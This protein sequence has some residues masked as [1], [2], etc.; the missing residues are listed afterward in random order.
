MISMECE[1]NFRSRLFLSL[2]G[3]GI[4]G[5]LLAGYTLVVNSLSVSGSG[6]WGVPGQE[7]V[8]WLCLLGILVMALCLVGLL[9]RRSRCASLTILAGS[10]LLVTLCLL[11]LKAADG[12]RSRG[13]ERLAHEAAPLVTAIHAHVSEKGMPPED[14][15]ELEVSYPAGH[16]I[17]GGALPAFV[18]LSGEQAVERYHGNSWVL[19]LRT[20]TGPLRWDMF[21]Y[22]PLQNY[23]S[24]GHGGWF[25]RIGDWAYV[26]E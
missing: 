13:F 23:P 22:Y 24:L 16:V 9:F 14:L 2:A 4:M 21:V 12:I 26:H 8:I 19:M 18:Y 10:G 11:S 17:K 25:E 3:F 20:P 1:S 7:I 15:R 6:D 5:L